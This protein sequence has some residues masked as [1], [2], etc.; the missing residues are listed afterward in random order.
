MKFIETI[1][2]KWQALRQSSSADHK[3]V[4]KEDSL[5]KMIFMWI[6]K[7]RSVF[8]AI[9]VAF[10]AVLLALDN[11][12]KLPQSVSLSVPSITQSGTLMVDVMAIDR[13]VAVFGPLGITALCLVMVFCSRRVVYPWLISVFSLVLPVF[14]YYSTLL[15]G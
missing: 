1:K 10:A 3:K 5:V 9:P 4:K 6:Y 14:L 8:L 7:L 11:M 15:P 13:T 12:A 2:N